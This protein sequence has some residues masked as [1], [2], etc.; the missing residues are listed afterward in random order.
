[1]PSGREPPKYPTDLTELAEAVK[2]SAKAQKRAGLNLN[3]Y[4]RERLVRYC[5][6]MPETSD[7]ALRW[8]IWL[9]QLLRD[10]RKDPQEA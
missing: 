7:E 5:G 2:L 3:M 6:R 9:R 10:A 8:K 1:M 4:E